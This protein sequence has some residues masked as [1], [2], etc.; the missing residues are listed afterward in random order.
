MS[1]ALI[2][3]VA[4]Q[5]LA[6]PLT[7]VREVLQPGI[8]LPMPRAPFGCLGLLDVRGERL[9][10]L[11]LAVMLGQTPRRTLEDILEE[12]VHSQALVLIQGKSVVALL[13]DRVLEVGTILEEVAPNDASEVLGRAA[14][15]VQGTAECPD[16][17]ALLLR[18]EG[19]VTP[20]RL[21]VLMRGTQRAGLRP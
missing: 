12:L 16:R 10:F 9:P 6:L 15:L 18:A 8:P 2:F 14:M 4:G 13:V 20:A 7:N 21:R 19:L 5:S 17:R 3:E 11:D 1:E